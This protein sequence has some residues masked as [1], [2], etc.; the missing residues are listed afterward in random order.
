MNA[1]MRN[2]VPYP[3][4]CT[5]QEIW[6]KRC[7][8]RVNRGLPPSMK[9]FCQRRGHSAIV[10]F[11][12]PHH[13]YLYRCTSKTHKIGLN[14]GC[15]NEKVRAMTTSNKWLTGH[16]SLKQT[17]TSPRCLRDQRCL[18]HRALPALAFVWRPACWLYMYTLNQKWQTNTTWSHGEEQQ[19][20]P[21]SSNNTGLYPFFCYFYGFRIGLIWHSMYVYMYKWC[22]LLTVCLG[23]KAC[24]CYLKCVRECTSASH[25]PILQ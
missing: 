11:V 5:C 21:W 22:W 12:R 9:L 24:K 8:P 19:Q 23:G 13:D 15:T 17:A 20:A 14:G 4:S 16:H 18:C 10:C 3:R 25:A 2:A 6:T 7:T 1:V